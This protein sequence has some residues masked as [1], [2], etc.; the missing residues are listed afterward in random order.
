[1]ELAVLQHQY[2]LIDLA[3]HHIQHN[4]R[5]KISREVWMRSWS[6]IGNRSQFGMYDPR[7]SGGAPK[8]GPTMLPELHADGPGDVR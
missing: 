7:A 2:D 4:R 6:W 1:M 8:R 5:K 3:I